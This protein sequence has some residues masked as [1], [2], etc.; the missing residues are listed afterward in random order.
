MPAMTV[1]LSVVFLSFIQLST[2]LGIG[3]FSIYNEE[4][5]KCVIVKSTNSVIAG[6]CAPTDPNQQFRWISENRVMSIAFT[7]CLGVPAKK[8]WV[9]VTLYPCDAKSEFQK[10]ECRNET[11]F[12]L[13]G[14]DL[15]FNYG[16]KNEKN[17]MLYKGSGTWSRWIT[18]GT[19][20]DLCSRGYDDIFSLSGNG[21]GQS[22]AFPFLFQNKWYADCTKDGRAD[23]LSWC[24]TT[25]NYDTDGKYG[26]CPIKSTSECGKFWVKDPM[27]GVCYQISKEA[28]LT[29]HEAGKSCQQQNAELLSVTELTEQT[30]LS[31]LTNELSS[32]LW[33]G[34]HSLD[35]HV[36][37]QWKDGG[38]F[39]YLNWAPGNPAGQPGKN[40]ASLHPGKNAK[41]ENCECGLKLGYICKKGNTT[42]NLFIDPS[43]NNLH[44]KCPDQ[45]VP[46]AGNCYT[47]KREAKMWKDALV[48]CRKEEADLASIHNIEEHSFIFSQL[49]YLPTD[50]LWIGLNDQKHHMLF[51]WSDMTPVTFTIWK[52]GEPSHLQNRQEDC[53]LIEGKD[54]YWADHI[55]E[56]KHGYICKR[57]PLSMTHEDLAITEK[58]CKM[59]WKR[60][61]FYCYFI[62]S[63][64]KTFAEANQTCR[65]DGAYL[66]TV[67]D[68]YEQAYLTSLIGLRPEKYF[69]LGMSDIQKRGTFT[70]TDLETVTFTNWNVRMPGSQSGCVA[71]RTGI[72]AGLWDIVK[73]E[74]KVKY[75]CKHWAEG[76]TSPPVP[77]TTPAPQC[78]E[79]W[80]STSNSKY[81]YK[82][83]F[84][85][86]ETKKTWYEARDYCRDIGGDLASIH[87]KDEEYAIDTGITF[88]GRYSH[89]YWIGLNI[90]DPTKGYVWTDDSPMDYTN[91]NYGEP[92]NHHG[93][94]L[95]V[96]LRPSSRM[97]WNDRHCEY[98]NDWICQIKK[99]A[100]VKSIAINTSVTE[101]NTTEDGWV[102]CNG[103]DYYFSKDNVPM[104][105]AR[106]F[107]K[108]NFGDL[109]VIDGESER[110]FVWRQI[111]KS[112]INNFYIGLILGLDGTFRWMD[113]S[114]L[115]YVA[116]DANEPNFANN[117]ENCVVVYKDMGFWND[118]NCGF[119]NPFICERPSNFIN[120]T[121]LPTTPTPVKGGCPEG[122]LGFG[123]KC[124]GIFGKTAEEQLIWLAARNECLSFGGN[125]VSIMNARE[126]AF[127]T[128]NLRNMN[129]GF[130][131]GL[132]DINQEFQFL[133]TDGRPV[134]YTNWAKNYPKGYSENSQYGFSI[135]DCVLIATG[136][137]SES[138]YWLDED[139][140]LSRG[141]ICY[142]S[143]D[144]NIP[145]KPTAD[146]IK[147]TITFDNNT[148]RIVQ[149][150]MKWDDAMSECT[151]K[152]Y[153][154]VSILNVYE[155]AFLWLQVLKFGEPIWLGLN[156]KK[157]GGQ[158]KWTDKW[159]LRFT[160][161]GPSQPDKNMAC[162]YMDVDG[163]W[164][165]SSCDNES[166]VI[167]KKSDDVPP[168]DPPEHP[169]KCPD[170]I[171]GK[172]WVPFR[173]YCYFFEA[174][175]SKSWGQASLDCLRQG[176][177]LVSIED[178]LEERFLWHS[179]ELLS[180]KTRSFWIG[181]FRNVDGQWLWIDNSAVEFV[182]WADGKPSGEDDTSHE[183]CV[184]M[185]SAKGTWNNNY[186]RSYRGYIC[187]TAKIIEPT[188]KPV[189]TDNN[190]GMTGGHEAPAS[191]SVTG[192][193]VFIVIV[194]LA[195]T[196]GAAYYYYR[197][198]QK[199]FTNE[200]NFDNSL[201]FNSESLGEAGD[202]RVLVAS[203]EQNEHAT[204]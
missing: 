197:R 193:V 189:R 99:G 88:E 62:G 157:T 35:F 180:D 17:I 148:Y 55:C 135:V 94:E 156:S 10:W 122:W 145:Q 164:K 70:W 198:R 146:T 84:G 161:W 177:S 176:A 120:T 89:L 45:W 7:Q 27:S 43:V 95:C 52:Q 133:W 15:H 33:I 136:K 126:Q 125:L 20:D 46:Y 173:G 1:T 100:E 64:A 42:R 77:T 127:L 5:K 175:Y 140:K 167:C 98:F 149:S 4:H 6:N 25:E 191:H 114:P 118:I 30:Y 153:N 110:R 196:G 23:G 190:G 85:T 31:G 152:G 155:N 172:D 170:A 165:T 53:V 150:K 185:Y 179:T 144:P 141:Y 154:L 109:A 96:E 200:D 16:N 130:W 90:L 101:Y 137:V 199:P 75:I 113:G 2:Q 12:A 97:F 9:P 91:W 22:C 80:F 47:I 194:I 203:I 26:F 181:M 131:I 79:G 63:T 108:K 28:A 142:K 132:N 202:K 119:P 86:R 83:F 48:S 166:Y 104:E 201:Y 13:S 183:D 102:I 138:G 182:N 65:S 92:N 159:K 116:W 67:E 111:A 21:N 74:E 38:P 117:D 168:T 158:Y 105:Q 192:V 69:W 37:W 66:V 160:K 162:V 186:C 3:I 61:G 29:W 87:T 56:K 36:G 39:R 123:N 134:Y 151:A 19:N 54:G 8:D 32:P 49:G 178:E 51:E 121:V 58:G 112:E 44:I 40:C 169:G 11:L 14:V 41:W 93:I 188:S 124:Y 78:S 73:C 174:S 187:K 18:F 128:V 106:A 195:S 139:C 147:D 60:H 103:S 115:T 82:H 171:K 129:V 76:V 107:C 57:K 204:V 81:C 163:L 72:N 143:R 71:M 59:G 68:R 34:L 50:I 24:A 184:E